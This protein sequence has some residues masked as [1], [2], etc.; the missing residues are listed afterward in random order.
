MTKRLILP[1]LCLI[2]FTT[3]ASAQ[4]DAPLVS[5]SP[6]QV[7]ACGCE[8][9]SFDV[10]L[11][12]P[13]STSKRFGLSVAS[14]GGVWS[15]LKPENI[16]ISAGSEETLRLYARAPC[17]DAGSYPLILSVESRLIASSDSCAP[18][19][20]EVLLTAMQCEEP[21]ADEDSRPTSTDDS[22]QDKQDQGQDQA[23]TGFA[24]A[25]D[26]YL[27][28]GN[29]WM[30]TTFFFAIVTLLLILTLNRRQGRR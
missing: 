1:V 30:F 8:T 15:S 26:I 6:D 19:Q 12:N 20:K 14:P 9:V 23:P 21:A 4:S 22:I 16:I 13:S 18:F 17:D 29:P 2:I 27:S 11:R 3:L 24:Q 7:V 10:T 28:I 25:G 5:V